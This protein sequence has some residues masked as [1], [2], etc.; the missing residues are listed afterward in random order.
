MPAQTP[1]Q[2][3]VELAQSFNTSTVDEDIYEFGAPAPHV[4]FQGI[5]RDG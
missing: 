5:E 2:A 1:N 4:D 3:K